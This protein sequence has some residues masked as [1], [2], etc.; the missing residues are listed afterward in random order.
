[1]ITTKQKANGYNKAYTLFGG[2]HTTCVL[3]GNQLYICIN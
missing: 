1:M 2:M 3:V